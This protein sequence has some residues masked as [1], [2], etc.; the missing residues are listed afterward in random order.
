M[1][2][3][4]GFNF[5]TPRDLKTGYMALFTGFDFPNTFMIAMMFELNKIGVISKTNQEMFEDF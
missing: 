3:A 2:V 5:L 1:P 4:T